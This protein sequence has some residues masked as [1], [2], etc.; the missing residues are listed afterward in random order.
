MFIV[1][2]SFDFIA[3]PIVHP[4]FKREFF[5]AVKRQSP[6]TRSDKVIK[7]SDWSSL[8]VAKLSPW[9]QLDS[10]DPVARR[11]SEK[12]KFVITLEV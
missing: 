4:R 7:V 6:V 12:V 2:T 5:R 8:V 11:N 10:N 3:S 9:I 1:F